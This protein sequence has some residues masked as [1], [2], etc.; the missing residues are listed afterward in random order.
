MGTQRLSKT[1]RLFWLGRYVE[2]VLDSIGYMDGVYD[3]AL[4]GIEFDYED[5][6]NRLEVPCNYTSTWDFLVHFFS[7]T[8]VPYSIA[9]SMGYAFDNGVVLRG[10]ISSQSLSYLQMSK[11]IMDGLAINSAPMLDMQTIVDYLLAF[12]GCV[13]ESVIGD[14][15]MI[16]KVGFS[17]ERLDLMLRL[18]Y[19]L[20]NLQRE[21]DRLASRLQRSRINR[22][23]HRLLL[24]YT[25]LPS[26]SDPENRKL[27]VECLENLFPDA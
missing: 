5:F 22:D 27:M 19:D 1:N 20:E 10:T 24:L 23:G 8:N 3:E 25:L 7:D 26:A 12:K 15:R 13:D 18:D 14:G 4:D 11:N 17:V 16:V 6:C 21:F 9:S 2:R